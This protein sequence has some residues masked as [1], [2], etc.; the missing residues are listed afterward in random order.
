MDMAIY[1]DQIGNVQV[2]YGMPILYQIEKAYLLVI[3]IH[4]YLKR[5]NSYYSGI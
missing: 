1:H 3:I 5:G 2:D 4:F